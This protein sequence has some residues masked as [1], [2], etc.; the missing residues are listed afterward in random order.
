MELNLAV[1]GAT[2][3]VGQ[4]M[5]KLLEDREFPATNVRFLASKR[6]TGQT[7]SFRGCTYPVEE[8]TTDSFAGTDLALAST[9]D[10]IARDF[11]PLA[12]RAGCVVIDESGYF[13]MNPDVPL[14]IPEVNAHAIERHNGI[15]ASPNCS[16]TQMA[17][18]LKP[19][20]DFAHVTRVVVST[21]QSAS[22]AGRNASE[23]LDTQTMSLLRGEDPVVGG[24]CLDPGGAVNDQTSAITGKVAGA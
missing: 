21:Y 16:T 12:V 18:S 1:V 20:H 2:G 8:L 11:L 4:I 14:V 6:S 23:E 17:L 3:N 7:I 13:R 10:D 5:V 15:I 24:V 22:G 9:P 19:L